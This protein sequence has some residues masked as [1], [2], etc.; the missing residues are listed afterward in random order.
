M[1]TF[2][3]NLPMIILF[4]IVGTITFFYLRSKHIEKLELIK[5]GES[6]VHQ[7]ALQQ[8]KYSNLARGIITT[9]LALG[10][11]I[12]HLLETQTSLEPVVVY[13]S[14]VFLFFGIGSLI[15][16]AIIKNN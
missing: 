9:S 7:D 10:I 1:L 12:A 8:M 3:N 15:F 2:W 11:F 13:I 16:Y 6:L 4:I 5:K 14:M